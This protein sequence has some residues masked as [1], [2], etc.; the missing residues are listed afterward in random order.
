MLRLVSLLT[1]LVLALVCVWLAVANRDLVTVSLDP[2]PFVLP[3]IPLFFVGLAGVFIGILSVM[4]TAS[5]KAFLLRR[6]IKKAEK[7]IA[8][9]EKERGQLMA[10]RDSLAAQVR[11]EDK[12]FADAQLA[13]LAPAGTLTGPANANQTVLPG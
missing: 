4:P 13:Q 1:V 5:V 6:R 8:A 2:L 3:A 11:P 12:R 10:E 7:Q 9:L